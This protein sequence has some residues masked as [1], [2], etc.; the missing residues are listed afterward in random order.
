[1][2]TQTQQIRRRT[3][4]TI[5]IDHYRNHA[6]MERR[7][8]MSSTGRHVGISA[9]PLIAAVALIVALIAMPSRDPLPKAAAAKVAPIMVALETR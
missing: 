6:L 9:F 7:A 8:A 4:G 2:T 5:D 1:M 3:N